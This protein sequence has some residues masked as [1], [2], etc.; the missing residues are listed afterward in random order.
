MLDRLFPYF[1]PL[2]F[3]MTH[4]A[5]PWDGEDDDVV[6]SEKIMKPRLQL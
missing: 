4:L 2:R 5:R 6:Y 1:P 3:F